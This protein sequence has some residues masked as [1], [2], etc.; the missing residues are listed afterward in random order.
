MFHLVIKVKTMKKPSK[1]GKVEAVE[2]AVEEAVAASTFEQ[3]V[4]AIPAKERR[5]F[6]E[7]EFAKIV[8]IQ[9]PNT[10]EEVVDLVRTLG[11]NEFWTVILSTGEPLSLITC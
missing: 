5:T 8:D 9:F 4:A 2:T 6:N 1:K 10:Y 7:S 11:S 3:A